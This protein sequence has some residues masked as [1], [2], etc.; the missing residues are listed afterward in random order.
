MHGDHRS[1]A[2]LTTNAS[3]Q[4]VSEQRY[5]PY[6]EVRWVSGAGMPTD[7]QF[8]GQT[9]LAE[10]YVGAL[11]DYVARAYDPVLGRFI[12]PD[13]IVPG[14]GN[15]AA[16]NRYAYVSGNPLGRIDPT[17]HME[18]VESDGSG[19]FGLDFNLCYSNAY[20]DLGFGAATPSYVEATAWTFAAERL[21]MKAH[22]DP[23]NAPIIGAAIG[24]REGARQLADIAEMT[25]RRSVY[26]RTREYADKKAGGET[27][28]YAILSLVID[29]ATAWQG[30][31]VDNPTLSAPS[32]NSR[33][34]IVRWGDPLWSVDDYYLL[35]VPDTYVLGA[36]VFGDFNANEP[37]VG[38]ARLA[39]NW[40]PIVAIAIDLRDIFNAFFEV[41]ER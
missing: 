19:C 26:S 18:T 17:G 15:S 39:G 20:R 22:V 7:K 4:K 34:D 5:K 29:L 40:F 30:A 2:S 31:E 14:A 8:T 23:S 32:R 36:S 12:S 10:G 33:D 25:S 27:Q 1:C 16:F 21:E 24:T 13:T 9:R 35:K 41:Y 3:G 28:A 6:G 37:I 38:L 11:Y